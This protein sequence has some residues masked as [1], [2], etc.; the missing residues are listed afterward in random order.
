M[1]LIGYVLDIQ[2][3]LSQNEKDIDESAAGSVGFIN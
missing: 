3:K 1:M 2:K